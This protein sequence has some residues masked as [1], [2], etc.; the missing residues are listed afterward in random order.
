MCDTT[1]GVVESTATDGHSSGTQDFYFVVPRFRG[2]EVPRFQGSRVP[3]VNVKLGIT[4][5]PRPFTAGPPA[6]R[7]HAAPPARTQA[8]RARAARRRTHQNQRRL[9]V[10]A[11]RCLSQPACVVRAQ[12][13][14][15]KGSSHRRTVQRPDLRAMQALATTSAAVSTGAAVG[16]SVRAARIFAHTLSTAHTRRILPQPCL[17]ARAAETR[18]ARGPRFCVVRSPRHLPTCLARS[19]VAS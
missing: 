3:G 7:R 14:K 19:C 1:G 6:P 16:A 17:C 5:P 2:S 13:A 12:G 9:L 10:E 11:A 15:S 18:L 4:R 8:A